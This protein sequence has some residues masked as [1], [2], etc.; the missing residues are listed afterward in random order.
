MI[1]IKVLFLVSNPLTQD[2][3]ALDEECR[4]ITAKIRATDLRDAIEL[5]AAWAVRPPDLQELLLQH[6]PHI[7]HFSGHGTHGTSTGEV[8]RG[9]LTPRRD[10][11]RRDHVPV[12]ELVLTG[13]DGQ[14]QPMSKDALVHVFNVLKDN[15]YL[16]LLS[17]CH[18]APIAEA[19]AEV[20]PCTIG[21]SA[22]ISDVAAITFAAAFYQ[23]LGFGR[24]IQEAFELGKNALMNLHTA[25]DHLPR[26]YTR[27]G[28]LDATKTVLVAGRTGPSERHAVKSPVGCGEPLSDQRN[29]DNLLHA[30]WECLDAD[31]QDAFS[32]A[33]NK[34]RRHG[35]HRI[36]TKDF[37]QA[38]VR[39]RDD[40]VSAL[41]GSLPA[42][43][44]P[45]PIDAE[46]PRENRLVLEEKPLL[47]DCVADSLEHFSE[48]QPLPRRIS[49]AD[50]FVDI[51]KY[52]HGESVSRLRDH[53]IGEKQIE[54]RV[55]KLGLRIL[56]RN[57]R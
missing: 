36:S 44:L 45:D 51:A 54:E 7:V 14:P 15:V 27:R 50:M 26:L 2:R 16:V 49:S 47:S 23:A 11:I 24:N 57:S 13:E 19:L 46:V 29:S 21:I 31:L 20:I 8:P 37:F 39:L 28:A 22:V 30:M 18:S 10:M 9:A 4:E 17:A 34:K 55:Q 35:G 52:G 56:E 5:I 53:G 6:R 32:L 41:I 38:L 3:L 42:D 1:K 48:L 12:E 33:Y 25:E 40:S 43:A